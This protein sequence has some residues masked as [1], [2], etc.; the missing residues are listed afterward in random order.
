MQKIRE[1]VVARRDLVY[2]H[3]EGEVRKRWHLEDAVSDPHAV[4]PPRPTGTLCRLCVSLSGRPSRGLCGCREPPPPSSSLC[5]PK[6][7]VFLPP[8]FHANLA[9]PTKRG[10]GTRPWL[11]LEHALMSLG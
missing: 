4:P 11:K 10:E 5:R 1:Q 3:N 8:V 9:W 6:G 2:Q 7:C